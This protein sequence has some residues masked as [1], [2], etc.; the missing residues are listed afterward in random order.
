M[1]GI[2]SMLKVGLSFEEGPLGRKGPK[3][4]SLDRCTRCKGPWELIL[5]GV[6]G[7]ERLKG[8]ISLGAPILPEATKPSKASPEIAS[9]NFH[10]IFYDFRRSSM[11]QYKTALNYYI[12]LL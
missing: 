9:Y 4:A 8:F 11:F 3:T 1:L 2:D 5:L 6:L 7:C 12:C 10:Y